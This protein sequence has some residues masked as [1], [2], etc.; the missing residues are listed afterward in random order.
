MKRRTIKHTERKARRSRAGKAPQSRYAAKRPQV[1]ETAPKAATAPETV[2]GYP[3]IAETMSQLIGVSAVATSWLSQLSG[4]FGLS[5]LIGKQLLLVPDA[6]NRGECIGAVERLKA[7]SGCDRLDVNRKHKPILTSVRLQTRIVITCNQLPRFLDPSGALH[8]RMLIIHFPISFA[9][10]EDLS[11]P[12]KIQEEL[13]GIFNWAYEGWLDLRLSGF[14]TPPSSAD[15]L[16]RAEHTLSPIKAFLDDCCDIAPGHQVLTDD[17]WAAWQQWCGD[18]R[19]QPG[20]NQKLGSDLSGA[21]PAVER[22]QLRFCGQQRYFYVGV[23]L[24]GE[25]AAL[26]HRW[27]LATYRRA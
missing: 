10:R 21:L 12:G 14:V 6:Q 18:S 11:L 17:L 4:D 24:N 7:I 22:K 25:G 23:S 16:A 1:V 3:I 27:H 9:G 5:A 19:H 13:P 26:M 15:I 2:N 20:N 8:Y